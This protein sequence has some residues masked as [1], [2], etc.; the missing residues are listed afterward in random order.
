MG[1]CTLDGKERGLV[2]KK[3]A[4]RG[5]ACCCPAFFYQLRQQCAQFYDCWQPT[6]CTLLSTLSS[7]V[8]YYCDTVHS[9][10]ESPTGSIRISRRSAIN[11]CLSAKRLHYAN[12]ARY[13]KLVACASAHN[14]QDYA[15][16]IRLYPRPIPT[17]IRDVYVCLPVVFAVF[18]DRNENYIQN[19]FSSYMN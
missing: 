15:D 6:F 17:H 18:R 9:C 19:V 5:F 7:Q 16:D 2:P 11:R 10:I 1:Y 14:I 3:F 8:A 4:S 13:T 12:I